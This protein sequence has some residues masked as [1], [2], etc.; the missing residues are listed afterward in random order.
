M[1]GLVRV[2]DRPGSREERAGGGGVE[3]WRGGGVVE[4]GGSDGRQIRRNLA[5]EEKMGVH[6]RLNSQLSPLSS[7]I[8]ASAH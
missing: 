2:I 8:K 1:F 6:F 5:I 7:L 4:G 3:G